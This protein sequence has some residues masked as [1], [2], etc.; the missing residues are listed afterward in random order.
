MW[1]F[2]HHVAHYVFESPKKMADM[3]SRITSRVILNDREKVWA[4]KNFSFIMA[5]QVQESAESF[6]E[7]DTKCKRSFF[8]CLQNGWGICSIMDHETT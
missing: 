1:L 4:G 3:L 8:S 7:N 5:V 6:I 2:L